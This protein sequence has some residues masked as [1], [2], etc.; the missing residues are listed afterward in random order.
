MKKFELFIG[1][2]MLF[3]SNLFAQGTTNDSLTVN[4]EFVRE[5]E[6]G[7][8]TVSG[9]RYL[10]E[11]ILITISG[12]QVGNKI[13]V[14]GMEIQKGIQ[15]L[16]KQGLF[17]NVKIFVSRFID[18][19]VFLNIELQERA[20]LA[21]FT[22][23][24]IKKGDADEIRDKIKLIKGKTVTE[25]VKINA[26][27]SIR[28]YFINKGFINTKVNIL[29]K[30][31]TSAPNSVSLLIIIDRGNK[32]KV[33][34]ISFSGND[35]VTEKKLKQLMKGTKEKAR[36]DVFNTGIIDKLRK[37]SDHIPVFRRI[38]K[39]SPLYVSG[40]TKNIIRPK[41]FTTSKFKREDYENDKM[42]IIEF[43][44]SKGFRDAKIINDTNYV[45]GRNNME[46]DIKIDEGLKYYFRNITWSG[47]TKYSSEKLAEILSIKKGDIYDN[48]VLQTRLM[49]NASGT[50]V[51]SLYMD[52]GYLFFNITPVEVAVEKD[53]IDIEIRIYE[54]AQATINKILI[55]GNT[56]TNERVVRREL[57][58]LPG[59]KFSR[60]DIFRSQREIAQLNFF[61]AEHFGISPIPHPEDGTVDI[62][63]KL[64]E[65]SS[66]QLMFQAGW[67]AGRVV[68]TI[69]VVFNNFSTRNIF[70]KY[71]WSSGL[72]SGDGQKLSLNIQASGP[73]YQS[74]NTSFTEPWLGGKKPNSLTVSFYRSIL[75]NG[76]SR[77]QENKGQGVRQSFI[78]NGAGLGMGV[79]L[80]WPDDYFLL[81]STLNFQNFILN[82]YNAAGFLFTDGTSNNFSITET[83]G[84]N[85]LDQFIYPRQGSNI[86]LSVKFTPPYSLFDKKDYPSLTANEK[87]KWL[88]YHK[89]KFN[90]E[91]YT[92][93]AGDLVLKTSAK[94]GFLGYY[95]EKLGMSPF[96]RFEV[97][98]DG[99]SNYTFYGKDIIA[100]R[101]YEPSDITPSGNATIFDK[102]TIEVRYPFVLKPMSTIYATT[103]LEGGNTWL[104]IKDFNPLEIKRAAGIGIRIF[105]PMFGLLGFDYGVGIDK[106]IPTNSRFSDYAKFSFILGFEPE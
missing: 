52:D 28:D 26:I 12:L 23:R 100:M 71:A 80:K 5:Y 68:G 9:V 15:N 73:T 16:W 85:S 106:N 20:R 74:I 7:G 72:P 35:H 18:D 10:N 91:W 47:N 78:T 55:S 40:Y 8:I 69:G 99:I 14:P 101:G 49:G 1:V 83:L 77:N 60:S 36:F 95:N 41:I 92:R 86:S 17:S 54:G 29:E 39:Q 32:I 45:V 25:N 93:L 89:W 76:V 37:K 98:G 84:R 4:Y 44:N 56:K 33:D 51:S 104:K 43:Y 34:N 67:G 3:A 66:D 70:K 65:K 58:T 30:Q 42:K 75:S 6:I 90:Y 24:G 79:R 2:L 19:K 46:V 57:R 62:E 96:E 21:S 22:F 48:S 102:Y 53:S 27:N 64:E 105:L 38:F 31:D 63:Y 13:K 88:E 103:F 61:N 97:G 59:E 94:F 87:Y 50:D 82:K 11:D 81:Q